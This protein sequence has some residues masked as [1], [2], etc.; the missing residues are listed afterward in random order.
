MKKVTAAALVVALLTCSAVSAADPNKPAFDFK[1]I[2]AGEPADMS[3]LRGCN[4]KPSGET[5]CYFRDAAVAGI[6]EMLA[7]SV[8][9]Y[10]G[11]PYMMIYL[12]NNRGTNFLTLL[13]ALRERYGAPC[14]TETKVWQNRAGAKIDNE[15]VTWCFKT[16]ELELVQL[17][18][19]IQY[20]HLTYT[21]DVHGVPS[22]GP[23]VDF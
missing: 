4:A 23:T 22:K 14:R 17:S 2:T 11:K 10:D 18:S 6:T 16:G 19:S 12:F 9:L 3:L 5:Q 20:G 13:S 7:P 15:V 8:Y 21:D 1:G